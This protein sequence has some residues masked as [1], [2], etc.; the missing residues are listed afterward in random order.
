MNPLEHSEVEEEIVGGMAGASLFEDGEWLVE[1]HPLG[2]SE[3]ELVGVLKFF[4][5]E[6]V[7]PFGVVLNAG[8][9]VG[10]CVV[11]G[12][13]E[14]LAALFEGRWWNFA[15]DEVG[16]GGFAED[17]GGGAEGSRSIL[18]PAGSGVSEVML[19]AARA[20]ELARAM[21]PSTRLR[22]QGWPVVIWSISSRVGSLAPGQ[23]V[24]SQPPPTS[25]VP[26]F[27]FAV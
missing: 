16:G 23:R 4:E 13:G 21:W 7:F 20:A 15:E 10:E 22:M 8:D 11:D 18:A 26:G 25:H 9:A 14:G 27:A 5:C 6:E 24:W 1:V 17:A 12:D 19:A 2:H 3:V